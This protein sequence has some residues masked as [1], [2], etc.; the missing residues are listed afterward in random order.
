MAIFRSDLRWQKS[1]ESQPEDKAADRGS[2]Q[3]RPEIHDSGAV[4]II[5]NVEVAQG[6][7]APQLGS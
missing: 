5:L 6:V 2:S 4:E 1:A 7:L 3:I